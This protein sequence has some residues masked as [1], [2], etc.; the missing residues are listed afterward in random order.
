MI[1]TLLSLAGIVALLLC[2]RAFLPPEQKVA[3]VALA[4]GALV[5]A[6]RQAATLF[7]A[8]RLP[9][10]TAYLVSGF[11]LGPEVSDLVT[12]SMLERLG[13]VNG[14]AV[15]LIALTAGCEL[16]IPELRPRL[17][18]IAIVDLLALGGGAVA[19]SVVLYLLMPHLALAEGLSPAQRWPVA[20]TL[21]L[22]LAS[23]S[24]AV[25]L[26]ILEETK[27]RGPVADTLLGV[28]VF[29]DLIVIVAFAMLHAVVAGAFGAAETIHPAERL[30]LEVFGSA[31]VGLVMAGFIALY[32][33][34]V[35]TKL[36]HC[37]LAL[38]FVASE[39][40]ARLHLDV[41]ILC[42]SC[43]LA[44]RNAFRFSSEH[45]RDTLEPLTL[46]VF[47]IFFAVAGATLH[48]SELATYLPFVL[49]LVVVRALFT[50]G[51][52]WVGAKVTQA[53]ETV[54]R[55]LP[56]GMVSQAGVS[57]GLAVLLARH[58]PTWG[59]LAQPLV[60]GVITVNELVGPVLLRR[61]LLA[62]PPPAHA[63]ATP[64]PAA[65]CVR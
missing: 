15:G 35:R 50:S 13:L 28:V 52:A 48:V 38:C 59:A 17:R 39:L 12:A 16:S 61:A 56:F 45:V 41:M 29:A 43:G 1:R 21:G 40:G 33:K 14:V 10:V 3:G 9:H 26:A 31:G 63:S 51:G 25:A 60:L 53:P 42:L 23:L 57:I 8:F 36:P 2:A 20:A 5:L 7:H 18:T 54:R 34:R 32:A 44:L 49:L 37:I 62:N 19:L 30:G 64:T 6:A 55:A 65:V 27:T 47:A 46:P 22:V 24:P 4:F 58:F 11:L